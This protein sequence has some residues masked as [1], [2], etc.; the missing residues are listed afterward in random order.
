M[1]TRTMLDRYQT[2][3][4]YLA[5]ILHRFSGLVLTIYVLV[6]IWQLGAVRRAGVDGFNATMAGYNTPFWKITHALVIALVALHALTGLRVLFVEAGIGLRIQ[7]A[8]FWLSFVLTI[9]IFVLLFIKIIGN[10]A[11]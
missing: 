7:K 2:S 1:S 9:I 8:S 10:L 3:T 4:A 5:R 11:A 6:Y